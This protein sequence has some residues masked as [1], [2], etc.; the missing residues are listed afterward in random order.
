[1][2]R[3]IKTQNRARSRGGGE[4]GFDFPSRLFIA[5]LCTFASQRINRR[6]L[7]SSASVSQINTKL[8]ANLD[9]VY[10]DVEKLKSKFFPRPFHARRLA[11]S[12]A[13][14]ASNQTRLRTRDGVV[15]RSRAEEARRDPLA[16]SLGR[17]RWGIGLYLVLPST[18]E[19][20][21]DAVRSHVLLDVP[22]PLPGLLLRLSSVRHVPGRRKRAFF[23]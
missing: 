22:G 10:Q 15:R 12:F 21:H 5:Y 14:V 3:K 13:R 16:I 18:L 6:L 11:F 17:R 4:G 2:R 19:T 7:R 9:G 23:K 20:R 1:M 8:Q